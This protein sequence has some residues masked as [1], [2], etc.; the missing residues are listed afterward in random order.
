VESQKERCHLETLDVH[1]REILQNITM[2]LPL[3]VCEGIGGGGCYVSTFE[4]VDRFSL[5]LP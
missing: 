5:N 2:N 4:P 1:G 3:S